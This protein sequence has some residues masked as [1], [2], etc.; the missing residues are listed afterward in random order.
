MNVRSVYQRLELRSSTLRTGTLP[1]SYGHYH[2]EPENTCF[3]F[4]IPRSIIFL[5]NF[6]IIYNKFCTKFIVSRLLLQVFCIADPTPLAL[7][8]ALAEAIPEALAG[9]SPKAIAEALP[10]ALAKAFPGATAEAFPEALAKAFPGA[11]AEAFAGALPEA[12]PE[13]LAKAFPGAVADAFP[14]AVPK[15][16][17][18]AAPEADA[19]AEP[20]LGNSLFDLLPSL[21]RAL[22]RTVLALLVGENGCQG[23]CGR[24][25][26]CC[27]N[28][29]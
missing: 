27:N 26:G 18:D 7:P 5:L 6:E 14:R 11:L 4:H 24:Y 16:A 28:Y 3:E 8:E 22:L 29:G 20:L 12:L 21:V 25:G 19:E 15:A 17:A 1:L 10:E 23:D 9:A 13:A 2:K